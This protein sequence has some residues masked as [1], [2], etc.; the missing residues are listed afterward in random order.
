MTR[1]GL[2]P[3]GQIT[4]RFASAGP[5]SY[6]ADSHSCTIVISAGAAVQRF[7]GT[8]VLRI[9]R[10]S[11]DLSRIASSGV[12]LLDS[13]SQAGINAVLGRV[14]HAWIESGKLLGKVTF[15]QTPQG[16]LAEKMVATGMLKGIS[17]GYSVSEWEI[18]DAD[19]NIIDPEKSQIRWDDDNKLTFTASRWQ[20]LESSLVGIPADAA[21]AVRSFGD[22][23]GNATDVRERMLIRQRMHERTAAHHDRRTA[24]SPDQPAGTAWR[25]ASRIFP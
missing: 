12:P 14:D 18:S 7:Y 9:D 4:H 24:I 15:A 1:T 17:A 10:A 6:D 21:S 19:G 20:L 22:A 23:T 5:A 11:V 13:H 25:R 3:T 16:R 8:E 2:P